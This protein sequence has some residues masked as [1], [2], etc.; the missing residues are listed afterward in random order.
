MRRGVAARLGRG[1]GEAHAA[2]GAVADAGLVLEAA[3]GADVGGAAV[4]GGAA[5]GRRRRRR[6]RRRGRTG[7]R[8]CFRSRTPS[9]ACVIL[10]P[11][12]PLL[13]VE[14]RYL[15]LSGRRNLV[16]PSGDGQCANCAAPARV[17]RALCVPEGV[18]SARRRRLGRRHGVHAVLPAAGGAR[19]RAAGAR[20]ADARGDASASS[21]SPRSRSRCCSCAAR[22]WSAWPGR[23]RR[24]PGSPS[25][26]RSTGTRWS[27]LF[28][29]M[30]AVFIHIRLVLFRRLDAAVDGG[31][32]AR[33]RGCARRRS[34]GR[35]RSISCSAPS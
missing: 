31:E 11:P 35:S 13:M 3:L 17:L 28:F 7:P 16:R 23:R 25:T 27:R 33:R 10:R 26:C 18:S 12:R 4:G 20:H 1:A 29:V 8:P 34:A 22:R 24:A 21:P 9:R 5:A 2:V 15:A 19:P 6:C 32:V 30:L 14:R